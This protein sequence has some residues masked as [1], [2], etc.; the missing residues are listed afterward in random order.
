MEV[1]GG[2]LFGCVTVAAADFEVVGAGAGVVVGGTLSVVTEIRC[3]PH[4][5]QT[6][7][8]WVE[9]HLRQTGCAVGLC[10]LGAWHWLHPL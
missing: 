10:C 6:V 3:L 5:W 4:G 2:F 8:E 7:V 1:I 9:E